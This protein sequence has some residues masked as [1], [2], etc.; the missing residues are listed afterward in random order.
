MKKINLLIV[1]VLLFTLSS[2]K[3]EEI[4]DSGKLND[5]F[6]SNLEE[7]NEKYAGELVELSGVLISLYKGSEDKVTINLSGTVLCEF[8][9]PDF[10]KDEYNNFERIILKGIIKERVEDVGYIELEDCS[11]SGRVTTPKVTLTM[12]E[13][14]E[15][16]EETYNLQVIQL[17]VEVDKVISYTKELKVKHPTEDDT[18]SFKYFNIEDLDGVQPGDIINVK[19]VYMQSTT[20]QLGFNLYCFEVITE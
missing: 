9:D 20:N 12:D 15:L 6:S 13:L 7:A 2:C 14:L 19:A 3:K 1:L 17:E 8:I 18:I 4:L 5:E 16:D 10:D 11:V